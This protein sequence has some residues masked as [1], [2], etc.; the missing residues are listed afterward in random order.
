[1]NYNNTTKEDTIDNTKT[2]DVCYKYTIKKE[3]QT[4]T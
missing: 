3:L 2:I 4:I 1:M